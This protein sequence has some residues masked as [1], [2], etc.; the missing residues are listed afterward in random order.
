MTAVPLDAAGAAIV[1]LGALIAGFTTG[2]AG[3]GT[4]LVASGP[5]NG[6]SVP[7]MPGRHPCRSAPTTAT[8]ASPIVAPCIGTA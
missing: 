7:A 4:G 6:R 3:F 2:F 5:V 8:A 1:V